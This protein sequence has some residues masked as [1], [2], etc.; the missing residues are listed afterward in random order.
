MWL[1]IGCGLRDLVPSVGSL[2]VLVTVHV[3]IIRPISCLPSSER[4]SN[5]VLYMQQT[6]FSAFVCM[7]VRNV[8][9]KVLRRMFGPKGG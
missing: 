3:L 4:L 5:I 2:S 1:F 6:K 9:V 7:G 8:V